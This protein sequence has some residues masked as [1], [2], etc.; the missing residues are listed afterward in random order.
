MSSEL[1]NKIIGSDLCK[2]ADLLQQYNLCS[3]VSPLQNAGI[4]CLHSATEHSWEYS[5]AKMVFRADEVGGRIPL[6]SEDFSVSLTVEIQGISLTDELKD[7]LTKLFFDIEI[8][9]IHSL[10]CRDLYASWHL[11]RHIGKSTDAKTKYSHPFYHFTFGGDKMECK[12][13]MFGGTLILP[14]PRIAYPPMDAILGIDFIL[15]NYLH[16][17]QLNAIIQDS[18]YTEIIRRAQERL[19]KPYFSSIMSY[20]DKATYTPVVD[21]SCN[22]LFPLFY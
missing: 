13:D 2:L 3:D 6:E 16:K 18:E 5:M 21:F 4:L 12:G 15:Q 17:D 1:E 8:E 14:S 7:P 22:K 19:L 9:G 20:W 11:D 10:D